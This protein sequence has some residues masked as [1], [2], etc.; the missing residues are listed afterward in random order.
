[1]IVSNKL[2]CSVPL[3]SSINRFYTG[4][5]AQESVQTVAAPANWDLPRMWWSPAAGNGPDVA[6]ARVAHTD[7]RPMPARGSGSRTD[8]IP[9]PTCGSP[10]PA[11]GSRSR[12]DTR[13]VPARGGRSR[14]DARPVPACT[15]VP[16]HLA[17]RS[18]ATRPCLGRWSRPLRYS[19]ETW[20]WCAHRHRR[21]HPWRPLP[22]AQR[23]LL[24]SLHSLDP[25][26]LFQHCLRH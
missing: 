20:A 4:E 10:V 9:V 23:S 25:R 12:T 26:F 2:F 19:S 22:S 15:P 11:H 1:V 8:T 16:C 14:T 3:W 18:S 6:C 17:P 24:R 7:M 5:A 21:R 13:P